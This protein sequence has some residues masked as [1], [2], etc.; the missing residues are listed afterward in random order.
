M[1]QI[2]I[3]VKFLGVAGGTFVATV[4]SIM[5]N[6]TGVIGGWAFAITVTYFL[7]KDL[8]KERED[9]YTERIRHREQLE[10]ER[11]ANRDVIEAER[12]SA[13]KRHNASIDFVIA[14]TQEIKRLRNEPDCEVI[15]GYDAHKIKSSD[16]Q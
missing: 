16:R 10:K 6:E 13:D 2:P 15:I 5:Q 4:S 7:Y 11:I 12:I 9:A 1:I 3:T 14:S 8:K